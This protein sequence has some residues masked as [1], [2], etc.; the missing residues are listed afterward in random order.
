MLS[1]S[2]DRIA[3][4]RCF[5][6]ADVLAEEFARPSLEYALIGLS[7]SRRPLH[8]VRTPLL[9]GQ[10]VTP[11]SVEQPGSAVLRLRREIQGTSLRARR[12]LLPVVFVHRH[13]G[14]SCSPSLTDE[15]FLRGVFV[16]QVSTIV[17]LPELAS[18]APVRSPC[19]CNEPRRDGPGSASA[20][21]EPGAAFS[22]IV[23]RQRDYELHAVAKH[24]CPVCESSW[25]CD[26]P[27]K[28]ES[29]PDGPLPPKRLASLRGDLKQEIEMKFDP[30]D[31]EVERDEH[32]A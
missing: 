24:R 1:L 7:D 27:A 3:L 25:V 12:R 5:L 28:L 29:G 32:G 17:T 15:A 23:S 4:E 20:G 31:L 19:G 2:F 21:E 22:L 26:V 16:D 11:L 14:R 8:V 10:R 9:P 30:R 6:V 18:S 13:P